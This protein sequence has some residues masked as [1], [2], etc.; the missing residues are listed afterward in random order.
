MKK[1][2]ARKERGAIEVFL[3]PE[4]VNALLSALNAIAVADPENRTA[5]H[6][7]R[8]KQKILKHGRRFTD[9]GTE[10]S[11]TYFYIEEAATMIHLFSFYTIVT[12]KPEMVT[13]FF[14]QMGRPRKE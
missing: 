4:E 13:D 1:N 12:Q 10:S 14:S 8:L 11:V 7:E 9:K 2:S 3:S 6:A 5:R